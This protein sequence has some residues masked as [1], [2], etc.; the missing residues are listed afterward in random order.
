MDVPPALVLIGA[1]TAGFVQGLS[2][3]ALGL[4]ALV[5]WSGALAPQVTAPL[6]VICSLFSQFAAIRRVLPHLQLR[7]AMPLVL[8]GLVGLPLGVALLPWI[9]GKTLRLG[10]GLL[11]TVYCPAM[12]LLGRVPRITWGGRP[13]DALMGLFG[14]VLGGAVGLSGPVP[15]LWCTLRPW[16]QNTQRATFQFYLVVIQAA[17]LIGFAAAGAITREIL[18]LSLWLIPVVMVPSYLGAQI[19]ARMGGKGFFRLVLG[20]LFITGVALLVGR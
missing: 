11:L 17:A 13:V 12:L 2:G 4:V 1:A 10:V 15:T 18:V 8:G 19:Y 7:L 6:V 3:F 5:F 14:G 16:E 9:E 20:L